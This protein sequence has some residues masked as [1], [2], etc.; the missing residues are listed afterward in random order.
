MDP[1]LTQLT[2]GPGPRLRLGGHRGCKAARDGQHAPGLELQRGHGDSEA[3]GGNVAARRPV[4]GV[5]SIS[6]LSRD[7]SF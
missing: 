5:T 2:V 4:L 7:P 3:F 6:I 1:W